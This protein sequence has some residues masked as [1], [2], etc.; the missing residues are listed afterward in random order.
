ME[1]A[2]RRVRMVFQH[3]NLFPHLA[4]LQ[5]LTP[6]SIW[7][8]KKHK[9]EAE[10]TAMKYLDRVKIPD[11][12]S[13]YPGQFSGGQQQRVVIATSLCMETKIMLFDEPTS[14]LYPE[15][16]NE[17]LET[18]KYLYQEG[19]TMICVTHEMSFAKAVADRVIF[20]DKGEIIEKNDPINFFG[21]PKNERT[22]QLL[23]QI[24]SVF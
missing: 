16:I 23:S 15:I 11:Q 20:M 1:Q 7:V 5:N 21:N 24:N 9:K 13:K 12:A 19:M 3:F 4:V 22:Q 2:R 10:A 17:V 8:S 18:M 14:T 6:A